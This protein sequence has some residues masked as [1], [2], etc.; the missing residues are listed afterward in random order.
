MI[1]ALLK[2]LFCDQGSKAR[3]VGG[4][5]EWPAVA[6]KGEDEL[7]A[8]CW[9]AIS[10]CLVSVQGSRVSML[11][12]VVYQLTQGSNI[13]CKYTSDLYFYQKR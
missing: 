9:E 3:R 11:H 4:L 13:T 8:N 1:R 12:V 10:Q 7:T 5:L 6:S 2:G